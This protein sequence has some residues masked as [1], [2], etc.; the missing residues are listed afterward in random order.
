MKDLF[1]GRKVEMETLYR[2]WEE[3]K[4]HFLVLYGRRRVGK[5]RLLIE[6]I[7]ESGAPVVYWMADSD[8]A[9][10]HLRQF[11]Q[12]VFK[13]AFPDAPLPEQFTYDSWEQAWEQVIE[14]ARKHRIGVFIDEF[15][16]MMESDPHIASKLQRI[17]DHQLEGANLFLCLSGSHIG[18]MQRGILARNAPLYGRSSARLHLQPLSFGHTREYF[19]RYTAIDRVTLYA[20]FGGIPQYWR[21]I[22]KTHSLSNNIQNILLTPASFM[23][24]EARLLLQ[25]FLKDTHRYVSILRAIAHGRN[26]PMEISGFSGLE[27]DQL[28]Q[29]LKILSD[30]GFVRRYEPVTALRPTRVGRYYLTD[31]YL[32]FYFRFMASRKAQIAIGEK[33][34]AYQ[35]LK[36]HM[37][38]FT[39]TYTWE[40]L[41]REWTLRASNRDVLPLFPDQVE[42]S[43]NKDVQVDVA[44]VNSMKRHLI[45]GEC[46]WTTKPESAGVLKNLVAKTKQM[47]PDQRLWKVLYLGFSRSGWTKQATSYAA[48]ITNNELHGENWSTVGMRLLTLKDI[49]HDLHAWAKWG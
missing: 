22:D 25:D 42:S 34:Q 12:E 18:M 1:V 8:S 17:W 20:I 28:S 9:E 14:I 41:C 23:V 24:D 39:G 5:T 43:W 13:F 47:I 40:E 32:R 37:I 48:E 19:P 7:K 21:L 27:A 16:Y 4:A 44:G 11:S 10:V 31:P 3:Q 35:E 2:L 49:D 45:L 6:W 29:Y 46:K 33:E 15:T 38:D 26:T 36:R 30:A